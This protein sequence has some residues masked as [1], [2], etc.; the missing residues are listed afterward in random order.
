MAK[1]LEKKPVRN[2][3]CPK[4]GKMRMALKQKLTKKPASKLTQGKAWASTPYVRDGDKAPR[5]DRLKWKRTFQ[6]LAGLTEKEA[7][8][9]LMRD[10]LLPSWEGASCPFCTEGIVGPLQDRDS[11]LPRYRCRRRN[12]HKF[13]T[14]Q[15][16]HPLFSA[17]R[18]PEGQTLGLQ[19]GLLLLLLAGV[20]S[21]SIHLVTQVNHKVVERLHKSLAF[22]RKAYVEHVQAGMVF[23]GRKNAWQDVEVDETSFDKKLVP[24]DEVEVPERNMKWEQ[25]TK[26]RSPGPGP[27]RKDEWRN[28]ADKWLKDKQIILHTDS[29]KAY[30]QKVRGVHH[31]SVVHQKKRVKVGGVWTWQQPTYVKLKK[32]TLPTGRKLTVKV[33]TQIVDRSWKFIKSRLRLNQHVQTGSAYMQACIRSAQY[34]Y[35][36]RGQDLWTCTGALLTWYMR[37]ILQ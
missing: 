8:E 27:I 26:K 13:I 28:I 5:V 14:P 6:E 20:P 35:W 10:G 4:K 30:K 9:L 21:S 17:T 16:L 2:F 31:G 29:A 18:G 15:H 25:L 34:D 37:K 19:A 23:G 22:V 3:P 11:G 12:C 36:H 24:I 32:I 1:T 33:G 7:I